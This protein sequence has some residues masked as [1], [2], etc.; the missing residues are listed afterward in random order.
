M[1]LCNSLLLSIISQWLEINLCTSSSFVITERF[2]DWNKKWIMLK[3]LGRQAII[4][5]RLFAWQMAGFCSSIAFLSL[6]LICKGET[7]FLSII[8]LNEKIV[9]IHVSNF[10]FK[11]SS[12]TISQYRW[13]ADPKG[14]ILEQLSYYVKT[15]SYNIVENL[16]WPFWT[17]LRF[18]IILIYIT[19]R[20]K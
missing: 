11:S 2:I 16:P 1:C 13:H 4:F 15:L 8:T 12:M 9:T 20:N 19:K 17:Q 3:S 7:W 5:C 10:G 14:V 6:S 18:T